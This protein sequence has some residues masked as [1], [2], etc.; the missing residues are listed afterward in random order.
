MLELRLHKSVRHSK[1]SV[2]E[3]TWTRVTLSF[4]ILE[5]ALGIKKKRERNIQKGIK[6]DLGFS[7]IRQHPGTTKL[8]LPWQQTFWRGLFASKTSMRHWEIT[9][10]G[11]AM[12]CY[13]CLETISGWP[14]AHKICPLDSWRVKGHFPTLTAPLQ[15]PNDLPLWGPGVPGSCNI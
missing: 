9:N 4:P 2:K 13:I 10:A 1:Q 11:T 7:R 8:Y 12:Q 3:A 6:A 14:P 5:M 15:E